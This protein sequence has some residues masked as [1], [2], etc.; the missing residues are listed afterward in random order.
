MN[1]DSDLRRALELSKMDYVGYNLDEDEALQRAI[2]L[3]KRD[4]EKQ[5]A[6]AEVDIDVTQ[7]NFIEQSYLKQAEEKSLEDYIYNLYN[8]LPPEAQIDSAFV[9]INMKP[10]DKLIFYSR[11]FN[12]S[13]KIKDLKNFAKI[14]LRTFSEVELVNINNN[15]IYEDD[16][17]SLSEAGLGT[18]ET[19]II[20]IK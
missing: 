10:K 17:Q 7:A 20:N 8:I 9:D 19:I 11:R 2:E 6:K 3:S 12:F 18:K 15:K 13:D 4:Q 14:K 1:E 16:E 5:T